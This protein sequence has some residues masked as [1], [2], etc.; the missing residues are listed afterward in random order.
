VAGVSLLIVSVWLQRLG[1]PVAYTLV[2][3]IAVGSVT[4]WAMAANVVD[5]FADF[6]SLWL[7]ALSGS[8]ILVLDV[9]VTL[10]GLRILLAAR[11]QRAAALS[12]P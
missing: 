7:L 2:P 11:E 9:W 12:S 8:A 6:Q 1:R 3:M 5:Y 4:A 10:E